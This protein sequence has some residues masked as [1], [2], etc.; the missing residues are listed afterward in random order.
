MI[1]DSGSYFLYRHVRMDTGNPFYIGIGTK[2][3]CTTIKNCYYRAFTKSSRNKYWRSIT[4]KVN[5]RVD[6]ILE[7]NS[8][9]FI[10]EKEIEF[11]SLHKQCGLA[12]FTRGG[13]G[14]SKKHKKSTI[15]KIKVQN[16]LN[17]RRS[18]NEIKDKVISLYKNGYIV[19]DIAKIVGHNKGLI[20]KI[21]LDNNLLKNSAIYK[22][23][24]FYVYFFNTGLKIPISTN[25]NYLSSMLGVSEVTLRRHV[26][27]HN[28]KI[29]DCNFL[30]SKEDTT[31]EKAYLIY[32]RR[33]VRK[34]EKF[35][36]PV[37]KRII[38]KD[39]NNNIVKVWDRMQDILNTYNLKN[40]TPVLRVIKGERKTFK[41]FIWE[42]E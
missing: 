31:I 23:S 19:I 40:S 26:S 28:C 10:K 3:E 24:L 8:Y 5:Y 29:K 6:I 16:E 15:I 39:A 36:K 35:N 33:V 4:K 7:S 41:N 38:Q 25:Y 22:Q 11:I 17:R 32:S 42:R 21:L 18:Y 1:E 20:R 12:N 27:K 14:F 9:D 37:V 2:K 30:V 13:D 34:V